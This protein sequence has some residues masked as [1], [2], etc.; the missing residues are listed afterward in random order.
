MNIYIKDFVAW[1]QQKIKINDQGS[2]K[3]FKEGE[4]W[5]SNV[6]VNIGCEID[7]KGVLFTRPI[8]IVKKFSRNH[9]WGLPLTSKSQ[10]NNDFYHEITLKGQSSWVCL[11]QLKTMD[12]RRLQRKMTKLAD[13]ETVLIKKKLAKFL[14]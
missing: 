6:G 5:W 8:L 13:K 7:G 11:S 4:I 1:I 14:K 2:T 10:S 9:Y 12:V 3:P